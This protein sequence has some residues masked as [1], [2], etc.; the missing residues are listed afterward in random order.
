MTTIVMVEHDG[1]VLI[2][3][4]SQLT[5]ADKTMSPDAKVFANGGAVYGVGGVQQYRNAL[6]YASLPL[7]K[8]DSAQWVE[9][10][11]VPELRRIFDKINP[12]RGASDVMLLVAVNGTAFEIDGHLAWYRNTAG[13]YSIGTGSFFALGALSA[14][15]SV[16]DAVTIAA[17]HDPGT[18]GTIHVATADALLTAAGYRVAALED[19]A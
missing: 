17:T 1:D 10:T 13:E 3:Y 14:G 4:D 11:L 2:G 5:G 7:P 8:D 15:A 12:A 16:E 6:R 19:A 18:G 9:R